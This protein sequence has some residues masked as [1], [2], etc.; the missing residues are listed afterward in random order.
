MENLE[1]MTSTPKYTRISFKGIHLAD[2][3]RISIL[4]I[5]AV[6]NTPI[7]TYCRT[8]L[9]QGENP[10]TVLKTYRSDVMCIK[11]HGIGEGAKL[12]V[13]DNKQGTPVFV[14]FREFKKL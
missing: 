6:S 1:D 13:K 11:I 10:N 8:L 12:T 9:K 2:V 5:P 14:K 4:D 7:L 3:L